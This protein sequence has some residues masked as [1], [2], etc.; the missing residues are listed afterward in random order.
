MEPKPRG[1]E[2]PV[3]LLLVEGGL[4]SVIKCSMALKREIPV[5]A[6]AGTG[7]A[8][9][10]L[11]YAVSLTIKTPR[12]VSSGEWNSLGAV[13]YYVSQFEMIR[14]FW[15]YSRWVK[16]Q[17]KQNK[18]VW[19]ILSVH[20]ITWVKLPPPKYIQYPTHLSSMCGSMGRLSLQFRTMILTPR[21]PPH[22]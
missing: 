11:A 5:V 7:R 8:A 18:K 15:G 12:L 16:K 9:D 1:L 3:V 10:L 6:V 22:W 21:P 2:V 17:L 14:I 4:N 19:R 20:Q 13:R